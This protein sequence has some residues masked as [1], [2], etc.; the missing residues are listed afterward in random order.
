M[1]LQMTQRCCFTSV[2]MPENFFSAGGVISR[3]PA[4]RTAEPAAA[5]VKTNGIASQRARLLKCTIKIYLPVFLCNSRTLDEGR[6]PS[7]QLFGF[8]G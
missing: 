6:E 3:L 1:Q 7:P 4:V 5:R 2:T 8:H